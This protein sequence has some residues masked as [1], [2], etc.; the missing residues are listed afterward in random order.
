MGI[1]IL[2]R[3]DEETSSREGEGQDEDSEGQD[4]DREGQ[5]QDNEDNDGQDEDNVIEDDHLAGGDA[6]GY[7]EADS[8][9]AVGGTRYAS[10]ESG[11]YDTAFEESEEEGNIISLSKIILFARLTMFHCR[12]KSKR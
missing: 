10:S 5:D 9:E 8:N 3:G 1:A 2:C 11:D 7:S 6:N 12:T 4:E